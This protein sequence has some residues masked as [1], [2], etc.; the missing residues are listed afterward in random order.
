MCRI[1][2]NGIQ[3]RYARELQ[4][5]S[6][7]G[8]HNFFRIFPAPRKSGQYFAS[9]F[10]I[11]SV[12]HSV[13]TDRRKMAL[14][15]DGCLSR[16]FTK[17]GV[18]LETVVAVLAMLLDSRLCIVHT[19]KQCNHWEY[20]ETTEAL[21]SGHLLCA[22]RHEYMQSARKRPNK[23]V[24]KHSSLALTANRNVYCYW[25][26]DWTRREDRCSTHAWKKQKKEH[27]QDLCSRVYSAVIAKNDILPI[28]IVCG[29][30]HTE[31]TRVAVSNINVVTPVSDD[32][33]Q[34]T[35]FD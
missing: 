1:H 12:V 33:H 34:L 27:D 26:D 19:C 9:A 17:K 10:E 24:H 3:N 16:T 8:S 23:C 22:L 21:R 13:E 14:K 2:W 31:P 4:L 25:T 7:P 5:S 20:S 18:K 30:I 6:V 32:I 15:R 29:L 35:I 28:V 11:E